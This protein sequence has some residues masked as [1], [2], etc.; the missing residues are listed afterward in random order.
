MSESRGIINNAENLCYRQRFIMKTMDKQGM[1]IHGYNKI[2]IFGASGAGK[3]YMSRRIAELTGCPV[4]H[5]DAVFY[6]HGWVTV[7]EDEF[8]VCQREMMSNRTWII[9]GNYKKTMEFRFAAAELIIFLDVNRFT[10]IL[11]AAWRQSKKRPDLPDLEKRSIFSKEFLN[12]V[13]MQWS[14]GNV[15][16]NKVMELRGKYQDKA[17]LHIKG[18]RSAKKLLIKW[19]AQG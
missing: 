9:E 19:E 5:L 8:I 12:L 11:A 15:T 13:K 17:F 2:V 1:N 4:Y 6:Q 14:H 7:S 18:R 10:R 16:R 3:S